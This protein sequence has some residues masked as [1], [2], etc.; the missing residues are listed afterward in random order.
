MTWIIIEIFNED[1]TTARIIQDQ[2]GAV[3]YNTEEE[4]TVEAE[5]YAE[6][7]VVQLN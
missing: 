3:L 2:H 1:K 5:Q 7:Y 4:A 6:A